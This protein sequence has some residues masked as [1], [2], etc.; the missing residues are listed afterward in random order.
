MRI[1]S[2]RVKDDKDWQRELLA[3]AFALTR[4]AQQSYK[5]TQ[6]ASAELMSNFIFSRTIAE[7]ALDRLS[8]QCAVISALLEID[9]PRALALVR[10]MDGLELPITKCEEA[11]APNVDTFYQMLLTV[12]KRCFN[13]QQQEK[14]EDLAF[15]E[16]YLRQVNHPAQVAP[17]SRLVRFAGTTP[18]RLDRLLLAF[19]AALDD[20]RQDDRAFST[21]GNISSATELQTLGT[22]CTQYSKRGEEVFARVRRYLVEHLNGPRCADN[23][24]TATGKPAPLPPA[25]REFNQLI[26]FDGYKVE[27]IAEDEIKPGSLGGKAELPRYWQTPNAARM[28]Q[29]FYEVMFDHPQP[30]AKDAAPNAPRVII[31]TDPS[32]PER[33]QAFQQF[34]TELAVW[35][36]E[37]NVALTDFYHQKCLLYDEAFRRVPASPLL[38]QVLRDYLNL[39]SSSRAQFKSFPEWYAHFKTLH[40][41]YVMGDVQGTVEAVSAALQKSD[42]PFVQLFLRLSKAPAEK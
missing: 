1:A 24:L 31:K 14:G 35:E 6:P 13:S 2:F 28:Q 38:N 32:S 16:T 9:P 36:P 29:R 15:L 23:V 5:P 17:A 37:E 8:L 42:D 33:M 40:S 26:A 3:E 10:E 20:V 7:L 19:L 4:L 21:G 39:L 25:V 34:F 12:A 27:E 22:F 11:A 30:R 41:G 18:E